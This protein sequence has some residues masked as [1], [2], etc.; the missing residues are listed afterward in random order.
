MECNIDAGGKYVR[1]LIGICAVVFSIPVL[2]LT[3]SGLIDTNIGWMVVASMW[4]GGIFS[5]FEG[6]SGW[7]IVRA[8]GYRTLI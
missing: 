1:L 2:M 5:I 8:L 3:V 6:W 4:A 7:C